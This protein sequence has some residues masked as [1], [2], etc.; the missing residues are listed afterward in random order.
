MCI[1]IV[2]ARFV[3]AVSDPSGGRRVGVECVGR[4]QDARNGRGLRGI[5]RSVA[6][7]KRRGAVADEDVVGYIAEIRGQT[8]TRK[9][10]AVLRVDNQ[11]VSLATLT[12]G[13][14]H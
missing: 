12:A 9:D 3:V 6:R 2:S 7:R 13:D 1:N 8:A 4:D 14:R 5:W 10:F 11:F